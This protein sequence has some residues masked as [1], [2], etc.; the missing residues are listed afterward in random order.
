MKI[1][2]FATLKGGSGKTMNAFNIGGVLAE[3]H[4]VLLIDIDPQCN[5]SSNCGINTGDPNIKNVK[6][7][8]DNLSEKQ[9]TPEKIIF[10][11]PINDL[12][13]LDI[14]PSSIMLFE[15]E[16]NIVSVEGRENFLRYYILEDN[17]EYLESH[18]DYIL[19]DTNPSMSIININA[20][21][22]ADSIVLTSD[23][24]T[25][26]ISGAELFCALWANK[27]KRL[28]K[29]NN[30]AAL[31]LCNRD[32]RANLGDELIEYSSN[33]DFSK[34]LVLKTVIPSTVKMK[35]TEVEH[36]PV[37]LLYPKDEIKTAY[38]NIISELKQKGVL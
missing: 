31:I 24:S 35:N 8:F 36:Q 9:P 3:S 12:P 1:I 34:D 26:S 19:I 32:K 27:R 20:F 5:L 13:N 6:D 14:I 16:T 22:I 38:D 7:I 29:D 33:A 21:F 25:N 10:K 37:N 30:V 18:Y 17:K 23:V 15:T 11:S 28:R 2:T 4:K